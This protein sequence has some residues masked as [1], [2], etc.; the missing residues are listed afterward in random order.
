M[1]LT[2]PDAGE[3]LPGEPLPSR[4]VM[5]IHQLPPLASVKPPGSLEPPP[6]TQILSAQF[7]VNPLITGAG[8]GIGV[9]FGQFW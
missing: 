8:G 5:V 1:P 6:A 9:Q 7:I 4:S 3:A 2:V